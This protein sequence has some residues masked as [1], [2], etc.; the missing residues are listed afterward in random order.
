VTM[1]IDDQPFRWRSIALPALLPT[2]LFGIGEGA[3][4]PIIPIVAE[5]LG[6][7]LVIAGVVAALLTIGELLGNIPSGWLIGRV[8]ERPAMIGASG[9][10]IVGLIICVI[11]PNP[12]ALAFGVFLIG[13]ATAMFSLARQAFL[14]SFVP[15]PFRARAL[16]TLGG[17]L[18]LGLFVG[19]FL[20]AAVIHLT[21]APVF[22]FWINVVAALAAAIVLLVLPD[23]E[24]TF[25]AVRRIRIGHR[26]VTEGDAE[27]ERESVGL[28]RTIH[29]NRAVLARMGTG[30]AL[31]SAARASRQ[32]ILPLWALSIGVNDATT[33]IVIGIA[34]GIDFALF[35]TS[36]WIMDRFGRIW[37]AV[38][39]M[40]GLA[41][42]HFIL[43]FTHDV[44]ANFIWFVTAAMVL[45]LA[46]GVGSGIMMTLGADLADRHNPAPF[47]GAFRFTGN[48]GGALS[49]LILAGLT[50]VASIAVAAG[51]MGVIALLGAVVLGRYIPRYVPKPKRP[52]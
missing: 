29:A 24:T 11:A 36:G 51:A 45:S 42:G 37:S 15:L 13:L 27:V 18:R 33:A 8:G 7:S 28:F 40:I 52:R 22:A 30:A 21:G 39:A 41:A 2:L 3:I 10:A 4:I 12:V 6:G 31:V 20:S 16:S 47:L 34:A 25:G 9:V 14:A 1:S 49:P 23:P 17:T 43:A 44:P 5:N 32:V 48:L 26:E 35:Y 19:P 46:N 38:P 50:A